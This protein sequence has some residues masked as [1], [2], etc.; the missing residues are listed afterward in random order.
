MKFFLVSKPKGIINHASLFTSEL[1]MFLRICNILRDQSLQQ[2]VV[3]HLGDW[4]QS[5]MIVGPSDQFELHHLSTGRLFQ[6][7]VHTILHFS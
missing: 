7:S 4:S 3:S 5:G 2:A 6:T 1:K